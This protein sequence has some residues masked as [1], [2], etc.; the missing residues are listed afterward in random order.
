MGKRRVDTMESDIESVE[1]WTQSATESNRLPCTPHGAACGSDEMVATVHLREPSSGTHVRY[2]A[3]CRRFLDEHPGKVAQARS[4][5]AGIEPGDFY[6]S[7]M[8]DCWHTDPF[9]SGIRAGRKAAIT[10]GHTPHPL[11]A[12]ATP[13]AAAAHSLLGNPCGSC[14]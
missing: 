4:R 14:R 8:G 6:A 9:C 1:D 12:F 2:A 5:A 7:A 10:N 13:E 3:V 11:L